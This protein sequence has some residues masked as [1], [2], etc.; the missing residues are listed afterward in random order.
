MTV[1]YDTLDPLVRR[2]SYQETGKVHF[3]VFKSG[4]PHPSLN[5]LHLSFTFFSVV[6]HS[7]G[8]LDLI[9]RQDLTGR[10]IIGDK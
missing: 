2:D 1:D 7:C 4:V 6:L 8:I 9:I 5:F 3:S 10:H